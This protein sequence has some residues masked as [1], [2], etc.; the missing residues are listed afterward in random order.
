MDQESGVGEAFCAAYQEDLDPY[1]KYF[2]CRIPDGM[3]AEEAACLYNR[4]NLTC[5]QC[6][7]VGNGFN[8]TS[9]SVSV[10]GMETSSCLVNMW[11]VGQYVCLAQRQ[12]RNGTTSMFQPIG[13]FNSSESVAQPT[14]QP[15][16]CTYDASLISTIVLIPF[17]FFIL[18]ILVCGCMCTWCCGLWT[19]RKGSHSIR[20]KSKCYLNSIFTW[21]LHCMGMFGRIAPFYIHVPAKMKSID[22][23]I[24]LHHESL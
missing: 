2:V 5:S 4:Q 23:F 14:S 13:S 9:T 10:L 20:H 8:L 11:I 24:N 15:A 6:G 19:C 7:G 16:V 22:P 21:V 3:S 1:L 18:L 17:L 12:W